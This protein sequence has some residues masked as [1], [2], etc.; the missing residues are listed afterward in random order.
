MRVKPLYLAVIAWLACV[1]SHAQ[2]TTRPNLRGI[3]VYS[4]AVNQL[5]KAGTDG[6]TAAVNLPG[7]DG[8]ALVI[9]WN[10]LE[11]SPGQYPWALLDQW[12]A[13]AI[14]LGKK[15]DLV[16]PA[17]TSEPGWLFQAAPAGAGGT[18]LNFTISP[19]GGARDVCQSDTIARPWDPAF[20]SR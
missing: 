5:T 17:G 9:G 14:S 6:L 20:L 12:M 16:I 1:G 10:G 8:I 19:H 13:L 7:D 2:Q 4:N 18:P 11:T 3:Y 15:I